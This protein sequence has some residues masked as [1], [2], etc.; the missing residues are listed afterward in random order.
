MQGLKGPTAF[1]TT[2]YSSPVAH[3]LRARVSGLYLKQKT[4]MS[5]RS[6]LIALVVVLVMVPT[7][8]L[9]YI[10]YESL[11]ELQATTVLAI[12]ENLRQ[13][14]GTVAGTAADELVWTADECYWSHSSRRGYDR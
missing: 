1:E 3:K 10:Q 2:F 5:S 6:K 9:S 14:L 7:T 4:A 12:E 11:L 13:V 8:I